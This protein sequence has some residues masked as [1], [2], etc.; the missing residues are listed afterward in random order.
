MLIIRGLSCTSHQPE[1]DKL[2][3]SVETFFLRCDL[4]IGRPTKKDHRAMEEAWDKIDYS[5]D[6]GDIP[7]YI[8]AHFGL[9]DDEL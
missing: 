7:D 9:T 3:A 4:G 2:K 6:L 1:I 5:N 8:A